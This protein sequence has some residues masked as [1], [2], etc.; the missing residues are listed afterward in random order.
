MLVNLLKVQNILLT[1]C[2]EEEL[3]LKGGFAAHIFLRCTL[4][5]K[6]NTVSFTLLILIQVL[7]TVSLTLT[8]AAS[9]FCVSS[10]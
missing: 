3:R 2:S 7:Q 5:K 9:V 4:K 8:A 1:K 6:T 10:V